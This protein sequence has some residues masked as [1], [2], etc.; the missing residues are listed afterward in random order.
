MKATFYVMSGETGK[1]QRMTWAQLADLARD[2]HEIGGHTISHAHLTSL[3]TTQLQ[4]E[5][6]DDKAAL[7]SHG[8]TVDTMA[9]PYGESNATV[10]S[11][12]KGCGYVAG[13]GMNGLKRPVYAEPIP[14]ADPFYI[15]TPYS[16]T[17]VNTLKDLQTFVTL[18][19][20]NGG[21][22][23]P[24]L[25]H[26]VCSTDCP[27][28]NPNSLI[29]IVS[30]SLLDQFL[31]WLE[32]RTT[33]GTIVRS[34]TAVMSDNSTP[35]P[36]EPSKPPKAPS[37]LTGTAMSD[38]AIALSW[39]DNADDET[40]YIVERSVD[41][42]TWTTL[43]SSLAA[44]TTSFTDTGLSAATTYHYRVTATNDAG[45]S[46]PC[47][48]ATVTTAPRE[49]PSTLFSEAFPGA[50]GTPWSSARW[51]M[52]TGTNGTMDVQSTAGR[53]QFS[54]VVNARAQAISKMTK[55]VDT[56]VLMSYRFASTSL[57]AR[58]YFHLALRASGDWVSGYAKTSYLLQLTNDVSN[59]QLWKSQSGTTTSL[60]SVSTMAAVTSV[61]QWVRFRIEGNT[62]R[63]KVWT[64]GSAEPAN[65]ELTATDTSITGA[66]LLQLKWIRSGSATT[67]SS[68]YIDDIVV[69]RLG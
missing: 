51:T 58:G 43:T 25:I 67:S 36:P 61:K 10:A 21:G 33:Q 5:I 65:W 53:M 57:A 31:S 24:L 9:F 8:F 14:P 44:G 28:P 66:G 22:W 3:T 41:G 52:L 11:V 30:T 16:I 26:R 18:A 45:N 15:R 60:K 23:V 7:V 39:A 4:H 62:I 64:D 35:E 34:V 1:S 2:G 42:T 17:E 56:E 69:T 55:Q 12:A 54:N 63:A 50:N 47:N 48:V 40:G 20:S 46:A 13:R 68:V 29:G 32:S 19:E 27:V 37:A 49:E 38:S 6:C 59:V